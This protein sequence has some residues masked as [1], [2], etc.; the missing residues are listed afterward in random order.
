MKVQHPFEFSS[1]LFCFAPDSD[2]TGQAFLQKRLHLLDSQMD[3]PKPLLVE[4]ANL[5][6]K[7]QTLVTMA[8]ELQATLF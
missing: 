6:C 2:G 4:A 3:K 8:L 5:F 7:L 1:L